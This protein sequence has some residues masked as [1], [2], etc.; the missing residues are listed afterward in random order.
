MQIQKT[1]KRLCE[2][3]TNALQHATAMEAISKQFSHPTIEK[4]R[5]DAAQD[6]R[7]Y[8]DTL[9][10]IINALNDGHTEDA[11]EET[12]MMLRMADKA[13][14]QA[15]IRREDWSMEL[16]KEPLLRADAW[17]VA[18]NLLAI[19]NGIELEQPQNYA[20]TPLQKGGAQ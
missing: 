2:F 19:E 5:A 14:R 9:R 16:T 10:A 8:A 1:I 15:W 11:A 12:R 17:R 4:M 6:A 3:R 20:T 7:H 13:E 18:A